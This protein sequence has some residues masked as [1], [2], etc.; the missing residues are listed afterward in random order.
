MSGDDQPVLLNSAQRQHLLSTCQYI[1]KLLSDVEAVLDGPS[2]AA[3][4]RFRFDL[5]PMQAKVMR[6]ALRQ[7]RAQMLRALSSAGVARPEP[8]YGAVHSARITLNFAEIA[9]AECAP[10]RMRGYGDISEAAA[11]VLSGLVAELTAGFRSLGRLLAE[12]GTGRLDERIAR[13]DTASSAAG[14]LREID[15]II[16]AHGQ[17][18]FRPALA[19]IVDR[20]EFS[21]FEIAVFGRV[22]SGKSSLLN[23]VVGQDLLPVGVTPVTSV[24]T[25][26]TWGERAELTVW[27]AGQ[28]PETMPADR[29]A[30]FVTERFNPANAKNVTRIVVRAPAPGLREGIVLV[31]TPGLGSLASHGAVETLAYLPKCDH[32]LVLIDA[33]SSLMSDD[34]AAIEALEAAG[35][36]WQALLSKADLLT[37][38][39]AGKAVE[40][41]REQ[42]ERHTGKRVE[43]AA[44]SSLAGAP[45]PLRAWFETGLAPLER[46]HETLLAESV[47]RSIAALGRQLAGALGTNTAG[48]AAGSSFELRQADDALRLASAGIE[49]SRARCLGIVSEIRGSGDEAL[50]AVAREAIQFWSGPPGLVPVPAAEVREWLSVFANRAGAEVAESLRQTAVSLGEALE[51]AALAAGFPGDDARRDLLSGLRELPQFDASSIDAPIE[52]APLWRLGRGLAA[53]GALGQL[54]R[55]AGPALEDALSTYSRL[56]E[57]WLRRVLAGFERRIETHAAGLRARLNVFDG[58][59]AAP[60]PGRD[61]ALRDLRRM[62]AG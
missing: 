9:A 10:D 49:T 42:I 29:V 39:D 21:G 53:R 31:D 56:L 23:R 8:A 19:A 30:E 38:A 35:I 58:D 44:V 50:I 54:R 33:A 16:H 3:F 18:E 40:Y 13:L 25:R 48:A 62:L 55:R 37:P 59:A 41:A 24:P 43:V 2:A 7:T 20:L 61:D 36:P 57:N 22:S 32:G 34:L 4:P 15:R 47:D 17:V 46:R 28:P 12:D 45:A 1:D 11:S 6:D 14:R 60:S 27:R 26:L 51:R 5:N 52:P